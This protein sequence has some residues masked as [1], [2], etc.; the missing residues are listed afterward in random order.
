MRRVPGG[1]PCGR[2]RVAGDEVGEVGRSRVTE[3]Q[4]ELA[5]EFRFTRR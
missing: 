3:G 4:V 2:T 5:A 1:R